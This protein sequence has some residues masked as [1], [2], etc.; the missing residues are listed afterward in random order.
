MYMGEEVMKIANLQDIPFEQ[1]DCREDIFKP[2]PV[3]QTAIMKLVKG[4]KEKNHQLG[5]A[6]DA[7]ETKTDAKPLGE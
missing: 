1:L 3:E 2:W 4:D 6:F 7:C 5:F